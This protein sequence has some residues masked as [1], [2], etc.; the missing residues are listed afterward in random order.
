MSHVLETECVIDLRSGFNNERRS[1]VIEL[2]GVSPNPSFVSFFK[3]KGK[4]I[5]K[6]LMGAK[7]HKFIVTCFDLTL[8]NVE[9][10]ITNFGVQTV[11]CNDQIGIA[12]FTVN[13]IEAKLV[14]K[15]QFHAE[16]ASSVMQ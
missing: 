11:A 6:G 7:P 3:N 5:T 15:G 9:I 8:K 1:V 4:C 2:I 16:L 12:K 13:V 10:A 14:L